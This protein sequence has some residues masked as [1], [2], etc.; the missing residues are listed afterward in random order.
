[1]HIKQVIIEGFRSYKDQTIIE[2]FSHL[3]NVIVGRNGSGKSN[4]FFAI[5]FVLSDEFTNMGPDERQQL[6]HE[7]SGARVVSAFVEI[8]FDNSDSRLPI[9]KDEV[10]L[11]RVIGAKKDSYYLDKKHVLKSE[12]IN[13]LE[14]AGFSRSNPYYI[15]KQG[16][17]NQIAM[18][19]DAQ[20]LQLLKEVGYFIC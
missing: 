4:F 15:V 6:L 14:T 1:M 12:V 17:I 13:L 16:R 11:R 19:P 8:I 3:H 9:D 7:G 18:A 5:Q 2:P 10:G 20:R